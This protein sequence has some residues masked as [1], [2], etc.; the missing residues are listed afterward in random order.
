MFPEGQ[1]FNDVSH[2]HG[3]LLWTGSQR[4]SKNLFNK[5]RENSGLYLVYM[6]RLLTIPYYSAGI[7]DAFSQEGKEGV[8]DVVVRPA[9]EVIGDVLPVVSKLQIQ[10]EELFIIRE[11]PLFLPEAGIQLMQP[12]LSALLGGLLHLVLLQ[13]VRNNVPFV[14]LL[15][16]LHYLLEE[17]VLSAV[18]LLP[19]QHDDVLRVFKDL[20]HSLIDFLL[21]YEDGRSSLGW[22]ILL[23]YSF[24]SIRLL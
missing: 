23:H 5:S 17:I 22:V 16:E 12:P 6:N 7:S 11:G 24:I 10:L 19:G 1:L 15:L 4:H 9:W 14:G 18:P 13:Q 2:P 8:F 20:L 21:Q 3:P